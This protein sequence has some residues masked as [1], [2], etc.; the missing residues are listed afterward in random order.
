V[1]HTLLVDAGLVLDGVSK[2]FPDWAATN[3]R[4]QSMPQEQQSVLWLSAYDVGLPILRTHQR[5]LLALRTKLNT[6]SAACGDRKLFDD[7]RLASLAA[8]A[9][10]GSLSIPQRNV[11]VSVMFGP[12]LLLTIAASMKSLYDVQKWDEQKTRFDAAIAAYPSKVVQPSEAFELSNDACASAR[13]AV[14]GALKLASQAVDEYLRRLETGERVLLSAREAS[15][16][17]LAA[18]AVGQ[19]RDR[20]G[21]SDLVGK[22]RKE[23]LEG[24]IA[25]QASVGVAEVRSLIRM[26]RDASACLA[27]LGLLDDAKDAASELRATL[28]TLAPL[29]ISRR[30]KRHLVSVDATV[31]VLSSERQ[32]ESQVRVSQCAR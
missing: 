20:L 25:R 22:W 13:S 12:Q 4:W 19:I 32:R 1:Y 17:A 15:A 6:L 28:D 14:S 21:F 31:A 26:S 7:L 11:T 24:D 3:N 2:T 18:S 23:S 8:T 10:L 9:P 29:V 5:S 30:G 16:N 27:A